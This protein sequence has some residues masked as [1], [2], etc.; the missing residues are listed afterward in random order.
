MD[1]VA[2]GVRLELAD[3]GADVLRQARRFVRLQAEQCGLEQRGDD[4]VLAAAELLEGAESAVTPTAVQ[5]AEADGGLLIGVDLRGRR[6]LHLNEHS[7]ALISAL[8]CRWGWRVHGQGVHAWC[9]I[10]AVDDNADN[11]VGA[12]EQVPVGAS[13]SRPVAAVFY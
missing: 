11:A 7:E 5:V 4:A 12:V 2:G 3:G 13:G 1:G 8:S 6:L 10:P 9:H